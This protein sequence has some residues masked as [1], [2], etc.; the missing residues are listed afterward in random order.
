MCVFKEKDQTNVQKSLILMTEYQWPVDA[1]T[2]SE[3]EEVT[4]NMKKCAHSHL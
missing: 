2:T 4:E 3:Q 1:A